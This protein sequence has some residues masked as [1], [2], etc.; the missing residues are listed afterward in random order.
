MNNYSKLLSIFFLTMSTI[1][2]LNSE[3]QQLYP[4]LAKNGQFGYCDSTG[5]I[6]I[7]PKFDAAEL[8][9]NDYALVQQKDKYGVIDQHGHYII[10][11]KYPHAELFS[12]DLFT[13]LIAKKEHN[14]WWTVWK[15]K[16]W[17]NFNILSTSNRGP[18]LVTRVPKAK[19]AVLSIPD[20]QLI[21]HQSGS[22]NGNNIPSNF[23]ITTAGKSLIVQDKA[24]QLHTGHKLQKTTDQVFEALSDSTLLIRNGQTYSRV[25]SNNKP[26]DALKYTEQQELVFDYPNKEKA[27]LRK[28]AD[29][30]MINY[31]AISSPIFKDDQGHTYLSPDFSKPLP[32][33][34]QEYKGTLEAVT[35]AEIIKNT[36]MM[37]SIPGSNYF[38]FLAVVGKN[39]ESRCF[40]LD[41]AGNWNTA[42]PAYEGLNEMLDDGRLIFTRT[43]L[44]GV[45][46]PDL[47]FFKLPLEYPATCES[48]PYWYMGKD[49]VTAKYGVYDVQLQ[50]WQVKPEYDYLQNEIATNIAVYNLIKPDEKG[51]KREYKGLIDIKN[52]QIITPAIYDSI[53]ADGAVGKTEHGQSISFYI[54]IHT[55]KEYRE[56]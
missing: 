32:Q 24:Y 45:L 2:P 26:A 52:N 47:S 38:F 5:T 12:K 53:S 51:I 55:G 54:N 21:F 6:L 20:R 13:L 4:W 31:P 22:D 56:I 50:Q 11:P 9:K 1:I 16:L 30:A 48:S 40:L 25:N 17:P 39:A 41:T 29:H 18:F 33:I 8:F 36:V 43:K 15:W 49:L 44:R 14:A 27:V 42:V 23:R 3:A 35:S 37:A 19:W 7:Q 46:N 34:I 28:Y 10:R